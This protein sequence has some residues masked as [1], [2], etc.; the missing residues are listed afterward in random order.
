MRCLPW[1]W[2]VTRLARDHAGAQCGG[3]REIG[4]I[5]S[6]PAEHVFNAEDPRV[7][8]AIPHQ[9]PG[10]MTSLKNTILGNYGRKAGAAW[11][12]T[13][14][15]LPSS[16]LGFLPDNISISTM[17][18][19]GFSQRE[20]GGVGG[21]EN[22]SAFGSRQFLQSSDHQSSRVSSFLAWPEER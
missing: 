15:A 5:C 4:Q 3:A 7:F 8:G 1:R 9:K 21:V 22:T 16:M 14:A 20:D 13:T 6:W 17:T 2:K 19:W 18:P 11:R 12:T 10:L